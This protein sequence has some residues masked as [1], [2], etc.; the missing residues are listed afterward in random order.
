MFIR[1]YLSFENPS[2]YKI[3][4]PDVD[5]SRFFI[6][7]RSL[8]VR[9]FGIVEATGFKLMSGGHLQWHDLHTEFD[10]IYRMVQALL[11]ETK[12]HTDRR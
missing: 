2:A 7:L 4:R 11:V 6:D 10:K 12:T 3:S 8:K 1:S 5:W 9:C